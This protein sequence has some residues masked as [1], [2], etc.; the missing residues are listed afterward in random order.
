M[1]KS[2]RNYLFS[3][4]FSQLKFPKLNSNFKKWISG[5]IFKDIQ[6]FMDATINP[7]KSTLYVPVFRSK[8]SANVVLCEQVSTSVF[9]NEIWI[10]FSQMFSQMLWKE[11]FVLRV[12]ME[13]QNSVSA[14][15]ISLLWKPVMFGLLLGQI[16]CGEVL[17]KT[18]I[19]FEMQILMTSLFHLSMLQRKNEFLKKFYITLDCESFCLIWTSKCWD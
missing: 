19:N 5:R 13:W 12:Q 15:P 11:S 14:A 9:Y 10:F 8:R 1:Q 16:N 3:A 7:S 2:F 17:F 6:F 4:F 18:D